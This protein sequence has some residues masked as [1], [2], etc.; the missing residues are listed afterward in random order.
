M[1]RKSI[2]TKRV[3]TLQLLLKYTPDLFEPYMCKIHVNSQPI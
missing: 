1:K 2:N 3:E